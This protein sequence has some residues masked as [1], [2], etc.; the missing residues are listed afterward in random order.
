MSKIMTLMKEH[1]DLIDPMTNLV[2]SISEVAPI[3]VAPYT[4]NWCEMLM[5]SN[6]SNTFYLILLILQSIAQSKSSC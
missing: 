1:N 3:I 6:S 2:K 4:S 5:Q